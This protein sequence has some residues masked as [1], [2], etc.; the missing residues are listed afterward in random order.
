MKKKIVSLLLTLALS[1]S[2]VA[3][4]S[5]A[6]TSES[7]GATATEGTNSSAEE[8]KIVFSINE[9]AGDPQEIWMDAFAENVESL[10]D[11]KITVEKHYVGELGEGSNLIELM[12]SNVVNMGACDS[13]P[14]AVI[15]P[16]V[17][18]LALHWMMP[19]TYDGLFNFIDNSEAM[20]MIN[21]LYAEANLNM[22]SWETEGANIWTTN[23]EIHTP[24]DFVGFN[25]RTMENTI[26]EESFKAYGANATVI[27]FSELYSAL[28]LG[29]VD[30]QENPAS[31]V[32]A[33]SYN[34][35]QDYIIQGNADYNFF[36]I[37]ANSDFVASLS[38]EQ[39]SIIDEASSLASADYRS[40]VEANEED[41]LKKLVDEKG[42]TL[43]ALNEEEC[44]A[45]K[46]CSGSVQDA[47]VKSAGGK[48]QEV[49]D[50]F[51]EEIKNY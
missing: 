21:D 15:I 47:Y 32:Y 24:E 30:G 12:Q 35:V 44:Q 41:A 28:Q 37:V 49:L 26:I 23:K 20:S 48:S 1:A 11:G 43:V 3:C 34:E 10:S 38:E 13:G 16:E 39:K 5:A 31:V 29:T 25:M 19:N 33:N 42:M 14:S 8:L 4:G 27:A 36:C 45:F 9:Y 51:L 22:V 17:G 50:K 18:V 6:S 7:A 2:L 40:K 46:D